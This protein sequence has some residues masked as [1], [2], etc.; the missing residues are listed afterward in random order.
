MGPKTLSAVLSS[1]PPKRVPLGAIMIAVIVVPVCLRMPMP[2]GL[3]TS[4]SAIP[5][6]SKSP[7]RRVTMAS[8]FCNAAT[9]AVPFGL[10]QPVQ[11]SHLVCGIA[12]HAAEPIVGRPWRAQD[13]AEHVGT[14]P[15]EHRVD[16]PN[17]CAQRSR[18]ARRCS[19]PT[20]GRRRWCR[21]R[22]LKT[23]DS[24]RVAAVGAGVGGHVRHAASDVV[25]VRRDGQPAPS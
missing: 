22:P 14:Q 19:Q 9:R 2:Q 8:R 25:V 5:S 4:S 12:G 1:Q 20:A 15:V 6:P 10:P 18:R 3:V 23:T 24:Q 17:V 7:H 13:V 16:E 21:C 11:A